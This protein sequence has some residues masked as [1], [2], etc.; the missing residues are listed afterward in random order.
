M[1]AVPEIRRVLQ[2]LGELQRQ[3]PHDGRRKS[4]RRRRAASISAEDGSQVT[5]P[6]TAR[7][8]R[9]PSCQ[10][11]NPTGGGKGVSPTSIVLDASF[12]PDDGGRGGLGRRPAR[13]VKRHGQSLSKAERSEEGPAV[14]SQSGTSRPKISEVSKKKTHTHSAREFRAAAAVLAEMSWSG[15]LC[16][17]AEGI[18]SFPHLVSFRP[19]SRAP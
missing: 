8:G 4:W 11:S 16:L 5:M 14:T 10:G 1:Q 18:I 19:A 2:A 3:Q 12:G 17:K 13:K 6:T 7:R 15:P 9:F